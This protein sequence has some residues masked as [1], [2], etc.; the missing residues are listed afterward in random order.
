[1]IVPRFDLA[2]TA[3][4]LVAVVRRIVAGRA[5]GQPSA[6]RRFEEEFSAWLDQ[7]TSKA[8]FVPS[9]RSGLH[10]ILDGLRR[11]ERVDFRRPLV[12]VPAWTHGSVPAVVRAAGF[13][14]W[15]VDMDPATLNAD[16]GL[17]PEEVWTRASAAIV[18]HLYGTP[19]PM[20]G[21]RRAAERHGLALVEDCAQALGARFGG[22]GPRA[23]TLGDAA[24]FS[25]QLTKN[26]TTLGGGMVTTRDPD[27]A[28]LLAEGVSERPSQ[29]DTGL[30]KAAIKGIGF[31]LAT[32]PAVFGA[33]VYPAL[34]MGWRLT[35]RDLLHDAFEEKVAFTAPSGEL[36]APAGVC[37]DLG[38][39]QLPLLDFANRRRTEI[40]HRLR[41]LLEGTPGLGLPSWPE[42]SVPIFMSFVVRVRPRMAFMRELLRRGVDSSPGYLGPCHR[43]PGA[44][45][46]PVPQAECPEAVALAAEQVH[47]PVYPRMDDREVEAVARAA[48]AAAERVSVARSR[49]SQPIPHRLG[50]GWTSPR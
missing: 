15:F 43:S 5:A 26:F 34:R 9:A 45:A 31:R 28:R 22:S 20:E 47:L 32:R 11:L 6:L 13:V 29:A 16:P 50:A 1:V 39:S 36:R 37:A 4:Q 30:L 19:S 42:G 41:H 18:T 33:T 35:G 27:L 24:Y 46:S 3:P 23:G 17:V 21:W 49:D 7:G 38:R 48:H 44:V 2:V 14:P 8:T 25:F 40:G 10:L 12:L